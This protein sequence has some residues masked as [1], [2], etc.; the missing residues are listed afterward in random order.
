MGSTKTGEDAARRAERR[1]EATERQEA[2]EAL[3]LDERIARALTLGHEWTRQYRRLVA[4]LEK[5]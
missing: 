3:D 2:Y 1:L 4:Q 5:T